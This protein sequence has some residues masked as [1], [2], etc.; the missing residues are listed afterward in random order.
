M[1]VVFKSVA[2]FGDIFKKLLTDFLEFGLVLQNYDIRRT[3]LSSDIFHQGTHCI[4]KLFLF[5]LHGHCCT[6]CL[7]NM[8]R[9]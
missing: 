9:K 1:L 6:V 3:T 8:E 7:K 5:S 4:F 2:K